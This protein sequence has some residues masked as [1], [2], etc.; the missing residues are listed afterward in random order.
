MQALGAPQE[1]CA[2]HPPEAVALIERTQ[3]LIKE[4][5]VFQ[6]DMA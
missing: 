4:V 6:G 1:G 3:Q 5:T 2:A